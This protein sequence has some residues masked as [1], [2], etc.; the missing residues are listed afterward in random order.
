[1]GF[2]SSPFNAVWTYYIAEE[3]ARG[4][5]AIQNNPMR[6][7]RVK[8]NLPGDKVTNGNEMERSGEDIHALPQRVL[9]LNEH[10][11]GPARRQWLQSE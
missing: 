3:F 7:D 10:L 1:M 11:A 2:T 5:S 4:N 8:L 6:Y 9:Q